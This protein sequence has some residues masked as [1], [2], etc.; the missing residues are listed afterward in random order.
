MA[1]RGWLNLALLLLVAALGALAYFQPGKEGSQPEPPV[2]QADTEG[3]DR[4]RLEPRDGAT[5]LLARKEDG[6]RL[7]RPRE[8]AA[9]PA[10]VEG[11]LGLLSVQSEGTVTVE[12]GRQEEF[13][14]GSP[15]WRVEIGEHR[16]ALGGEHP[17]EPQRYLRVDGQ[18]HLVSNAAVRSIKGDWSAYASRRLVPE[19]A[20]LARLELPETTLVKKE[21]RWQARDSD[22]IGPERAGRT[23][24]AW[25][26]NRAFALEQ[27]DEPGE[28][29]QAIL[30]IAGQ[31]SPIRYTV[32]STDP[33]LELVR[34]ELGLLYRLPKGKVDTLL[35]PSRAEE[36]GTESPEPG[37]PK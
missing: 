36:E 22:S 19:G 21:D 8:M 35:H 16:L 13:G 3:I 30:H 4:I 27:V 14:L 25:A 1:A 24:R 2:T 37:Q 15:Q 29:P 23:P 10:R 20:E 6:W 28:G 34:P 17:I 26:N 12:E 9:D 7:L 31:D 5:L 33:Q 32:R 18:V 11:L